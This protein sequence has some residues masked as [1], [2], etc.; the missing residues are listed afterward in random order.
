MPSDLAVDFIYVN[1]HSY[2]DILRSVHSLQ[3]LAASADLLAKVYIVD[4][5]FIESEPENI[6]ALSG[7][8]KT[9]TS[10]RFYVSYLPSDSNCGFGAACNKAAKL[11][12]ASLLVFVNCDTNFDSTDPQRFLE[13]LQLMS[14][15]TVAVVGPSVLSEAG[16]LHASCFSFDP[17]SILL[18]PFRH[19]RK[20][21]SS[22][23][24]KIPRYASFKKRID[25]ITYEGM[26][27]SK[28]CLVDWVS[29]CFA[30][31][32]RDL[33]ESVS[34]FDER[35]FLYFEDVDL[36]RKFRQFSLGVV[37][38][39][40]VSVVHVASH[41]SAKRRGVLRSMLLNPVARYHIVSWLRYC[42]KWKGDIRE[43]LLS[44]FA[45]L[46]KHEKRRIG[47]AGYG[48]DF[49]VYKFLDNIR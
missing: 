40:R 31:V 13:M 5:S 2:G 28:P 27:K 36:C 12:S 37:F 16:L 47:G 33:F 15:P 24:F 44:Y 23:R 45:L 4:N 6:T 18:K 29:G 20:V 30:V 34:G 49:S 32:K 42:W 26:D 21:G 8:S 19:V 39:P 48:L 10:D 46:Y 11:C 7:F 38:D 17:I 35:Y 3:S 25:R 41:E 9:I 43:K 22:L 1:Y 14:L